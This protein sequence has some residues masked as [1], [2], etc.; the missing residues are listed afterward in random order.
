V[1]QTF[2]EFHIYVSETLNS[3]GVQIPRSSWNIWNICKIYCRMF[4]PLH[5][6]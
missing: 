3:N 5:K 6:H 1:L 2:L 4:S